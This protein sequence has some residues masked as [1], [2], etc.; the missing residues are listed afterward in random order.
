MKPDRYSAKKMGTKA[1]F[2][3][4]FSRTHSNRRKILEKSGGRRLL[5]AQDFGKERRSVAENDA[6]PEGES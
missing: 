4:T 2:L 1:P 5:A 3:K 6:S